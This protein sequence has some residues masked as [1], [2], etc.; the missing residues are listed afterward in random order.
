M[1]E[2]FYKDRK[3][4]NKN[5]YTVVEYPEHPNCFDSGSDI[6]VVYEHILVAEKI[7]LDR[8][9]LEGEVVH[10]L[11]FVRNNNSPDNLL[12]LSGPMHGKLHKWLSKY[13]FKPIGKHVERIHRGCVR[14]AVCEF[15]I[16]HNL[17]YC[18]HTCSN[19][20]AVFKQAALRFSNRP[21]KEVLEK[22]VW[23]V[24]SMHLGKRFNVSD[25]TIKKWCRA[26]DINK[27]PRGY[28]AKLASTS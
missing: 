23:E 13:E 7:L 8:Y 5:G 25:T 19:I 16:Y 26:M 9:M 18:S 11:D 3:R 27:P 22:L 17:T 24:P 6:M 21:D 14:C 2:V 4:Y 20:G 28:W 15:P 10:H 12:V 1:A